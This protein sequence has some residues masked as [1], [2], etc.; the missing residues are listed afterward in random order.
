[1][2]GGGRTPIDAIVDALV[3]GV[4]SLPGESTPTPE[5]IADVLWLAAIRTTAPH[6][7]PRR[8]EETGRDAPADPP[9]DVPSAD[10]VAPPPPEP[11]GPEPAPARDGDA[12][13]DL[14][15]RAD[16]PGEAAVPATEVALGSVRALAG[17]LELPRALR[18]FKQVSRPGRRRVLD[19]EAT[20]EASAEARRLTIVSAPRP[21][22]G[23]DVA[24]VVENGSSMRVWREIFDEF[25][26]V[27]EQVGAFRSVVRWEMEAGEDGVWLRDAHGTRS[28]PARLVDPSGSRLVLLATDAVD[29]LWYDA[30]VWREL[31]AWSRAM[32]TALVQV[33]PPH[34]WPDTAL[35][36]LYA[37]GRAPWP[38]SPNTL[39]DRDVAWWV[40]EGDLAPDAIVL[41]V[42]AFQPEALALWSRAVVAG[43]AW[44]DGVLVGTEP[45]T[46]PAPATPDP[47]ARVDAFLARASRGAE[48]LAR[49]L[50]SAQMLSLP[51]I[52][53][54][55]D[56]LALGTGVT[57]LAEVLVGGLLEEIPAPPGCGARYRF[58]E[59][60]AAR[61]R[62]GVTAFE[63]WDAFTAV[64]EH[65]AE[66]TGVTGHGALTALVAD[67][68]GLAGLAPEDEPFAHLLGA[69]A[70]RLGLAAP[71]SVPAPGSGSRSGG[72]GHDAEQIV[73]GSLPEPPAAA[74]PRED[75]LASLARTIDRHDRVALWGRPWVAGVTVLA[76]DHARR[77]AAEGWP[78]VAWIEGGDEAETERRL[79]GLA[80]RLGVE[81][82]RLWDALDE[83]APGRCLIVVDTRPYHA[84][85][86][87]DTGRTKVLWLADGP[88][89]PEITTAMDL[90]PFEVPALDPGEAVELLRRLTGLDDEAGA[91]ELAERLGRWPGELAAAAALI[92][93]GGMT[94]EQYLSTAVF[95]DDLGL[96]EAADPWASRAVLIGVGTDIPTVDADLQGM[97]DTL[98][99][100]DL[101]GLPPDRCAV[102]RDPRRPEHVLGPLAQAGEAATDTLVVY[103]TGEAHLEDGTGEL[104]LGLAGARGD[105]VPYPT[106]LSAFRRSTA[107]RRIMILDCPYASV[108][109]VSGPADD[110]A[111]EIVLTSPGGHVSSPY[112]DAHSAFTGALLET[113]LTGLPG[114]GRHLDIEAVHAGVT[115]ALRA[116]GVPEPAVMVRHGNRPVR[117]FRNM[118][119]VPARPESIGPY[120][121][122]GVLG[123]GWLGDVYHAVDPEGREYAVRVFYPAVLPTRGAMDGFVA[124]ADARPWVTGPRLAQIIE[125]GVGDDGAYVVV[126]YARGRRLG[127]LVEEG[128]RFS[129]ESL[130]ELASALAASLASIHA[131]WVHGSFGPANVVVGPDGPVVKDVGLAA[132]LWDERGATP[133]GGPLFQQAPELLQRGDSTAP[134]TMADVFAFGVLLVY[135]ASGRRPFHG[136]T[137]AAEANFVLYG[138][139]DLSALTGP[140]RDLAADCLRKEPAERPTAEEVVARLKAMPYAARTLTP[141]TPD[142]LRPR[143]PVEVGGYL[144]R[145]KLGSAP[146]GPVYLSAHRNGT[147]VALRLVP[148]R[149]FADEAAR[150]RFLALE[151][152]AEGLRSRNV[153]RVVEAGVHGDGYF[154][155]GTH[156]GESTLEGVV[157][158][159]GPLTGAA[160][161][162]LAG[163]LLTGLVDLARAG[164][165][166]HDLQ[167]GGVFERSEGWIMADPRCEA[168]VGDD[169]AVWG[170]ASARPGYQAPETLVHG[171][172]TSA[173]DVFAWGATVYYA[174]TGA[175]PFGDGQGQ[176]VIAAVLTAEPDVSRLHGPLQYAVT[177][178]LAKSPQDRPSAQRLLRILR[179]AEGRASSEQT[180]GR[181]S[182]LRR[183]LPVR[184][185]QVGRYRIEQVISD[186]P[187]ATVYRAEDTR[188]RRTVAVKRLHDPLDADDVLALPRSILQLRHP[189]IVGVREVGAQLSDDLPGP[190]IV[191]DF[192]EG[193]S[194]NVLIARGEPFSL[195]AAMAA[196]SGILAGL[197][198]AHGRGVVHGA[199]RP[200]NVLVTETGEPR[201][202]GFGLHTAYPVTDLVRAED[203]ATCVSPEQAEGGAADVLSDVYAAGCVLYE[204]LT[205][206]APFSGSGPMDT[207]ERHRWETPRPP[208]SY[209]TGL[210]G[211]VD[212][213]VL[214]AMAKD[215]AE[216]YRS[217][218]DF[219]TAIRRA[220]EP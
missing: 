13:L 59:G 53:V 130:W 168:G 151:R 192:V 189:S 170:L 96:S 91:R 190:Y 18:R 109:W 112:G 216:R 219:R 38:A 103:Y 2:T 99:D 128:R 177:L 61:L 127:D 187:W 64:S 51:L 22:R 205:G 118:A 135:A 39:L 150:Q 75:L 48:R 179:S 163:D 24:L 79:A 200:S 67:P 102:V 14:H 94:Y 5:Q 106:V 137:P 69:L 28:T 134:T 167:P 65:L 125:A 157:R 154:V 20:V 111:T 149:A 43:T 210:A 153:A 215:P 201:V 107:Q 17:P 132:V 71:A 196:A 70:A 180:S 198:H 176:S 45:R 108:A 117:L 174:A 12:K 93:D 139:P 145:A 197:S 158:E 37:A 50:A 142:P 86:P 140:M 40:E 122:L 77:C 29:G 47:D 4:A 7:A 31:R 165:V 11:A 97:A 113:V 95:V 114:L 83:R 188:R 211:W 10:P 204:M 129:G 105:G 73:H 203:A 84:R 206:F 185:R 175:P 141:R 89:D 217:A 78:V 44:V 124:S 202:K 101:W 32:P 155:A 58:R 191:T 162:E 173:S 156:P 35:G 121:V 208:S 131:V 136:P 56:R 36:D 88:P 98:R 193:V 46:P 15:D 110:H 9:E 82:D 42:V 76:A 74:L 207:R 23:L 62:V 143:D 182:V 126:Q 164:L 26:R 171:R 195:E 184:G 199:V 100:A 183:L 133:Q 194:L 186:Q 3:D 19:V 52:H 8:E 172:M 60:V 63:E 41:P 159:E 178:A 87:T 6:P 92:G 72:G 161:A 90:I 220:M 54:L 116:G 27:L 160:L 21:E 25:E 57:E 166:H 147:V 212:D 152:S 1:M 214:R 146:Y 120:R 213:L 104:V 181:P 49:V 218:K 123:S 34:Y 148:G 30:A 16:G 68:E 85:R 169:R 80:A 55:R 115:R 81:P 209:G 33:L 138:E 66:R 119:G 144:L